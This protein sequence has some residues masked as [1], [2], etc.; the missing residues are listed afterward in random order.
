MGK[1]TLRWAIVLYGICSAVYIAN[2]EV[3]TWN[4]TVPQGVTRISVESTVDGSAVIDTTF[5]VKPGQKFKVAAI[6]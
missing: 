2:A 4:W 6:Q 5:N 3:K 1:R